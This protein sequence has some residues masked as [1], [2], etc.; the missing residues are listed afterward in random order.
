M[1]SALYARIA[2]FR[3]PARRLGRTVVRALRSPPGTV[4]APGLADV[5]PGDRADT[6]SH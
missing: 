1:T 3:Q 2:D 6:C 4:P 5:I